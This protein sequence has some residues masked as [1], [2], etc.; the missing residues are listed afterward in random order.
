MVIPKAVAVLTEVAMVV[1]ATMAAAAVVVDM[2]RVM[3]A[4]MGE[5]L[6]YHVY[7]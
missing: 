3:A 1:A 5:F 6:F 7:R 4:T 2:V